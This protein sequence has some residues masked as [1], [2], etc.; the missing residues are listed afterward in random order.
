MSVVNGPE[1]RITY[2]LLCSLRGE[3]LPHD[4]YANKSNQIPIGPRGK[5]PGRDSKNSSVNHWSLAAAV[6]ARRGE[7]HI[8]RL[9]GLYL[10][11]PNDLW[12]MECFVSLPVYFSMNIGAFTAARDAFR[13]GSRRNAD[14]DAR[15]T[16]ELRQ[17][18][19]TLIALST[20]AGHLA[21]SWV[22][23]AGPRGGSEKQPQPGKE[24]RGQLEYIV[25]TAAGWDHDRIRRQALQGEA[26]LRQVSGDD[27]KRAGTMIGSLLTELAPSL[28]EDAEP[29]WRLFQQGGY[30]EL[31]E[32]ALVGGR[33]TRF[34]FRW[35][36]TAGGLVV[37]LKDHGNPNKAP[38][39]VER[40]E[41]GD[42]APEGFPYGAKKTGGV[43]ECSAEFNLGAG[44]VRAWAEGVGEW[45]RPL[46]GGDVDFD[47]ESDRRGVRSL[48]ASAPPVDPP[49]PPPPPQEPPTPGPGPTPDPE[50]SRWERFQKWVAE[51][52]AKVGL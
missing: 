43:V 16:A 45:E 10:D 2:E 51:W 39:V 26:I 9:F 6:A 28:Q 47:L 44:V 40:W 19:A 25:L 33:G 15:L 22:L 20:E 13:R 21:R 4:E 30:R 3:P 35:R 29:A 5:Q 12:M 7:Q 48:L 38:K 27:P 42:R 8:P 52:L 41:T 14:L 37:A 11:E 50:P 32:R 46:P 24:T 17:I 23:M 18:H 31:A 1:D 34:P 36:R 49:P